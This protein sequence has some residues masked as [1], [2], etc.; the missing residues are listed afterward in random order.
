MTTQLRPLSLGEILDRTTQLYRANFLTFAGIA[1]VPTILILLATIPL[2]GTAGLMGVYG[3]AAAAANGPFLAGVMAGGTVFGIVLL[4]ATVFSQAALVRAV[5]G[6]HTGR[7]LAVRQ[8]LGSVKPRFWR[9]LGVLLLQ[10]ILIGVVPAV[11]A[12]VVIGIV[13]ALTHASGGD[14]GANVIA[15][16]VSFFIA[17][18]TFVIII[19]RGLSYSLAM[20]AC[21]AEEKPAW[22]S[23]QRSKKLSHG[24]RGRIFLM[25]LL[26]WVLAMVVSMGGYIAMLIV[27]AVAALVNKG[28][29]MG[30]SVIVAGEVVNMLVNLSI[31]TV[32][33]PVYVTALVL[34]YYDQRIRTEGY[35]I[36][37]MMEHAG[38]TGSQPEIAGTAPDAGTLNG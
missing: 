20:P 37:W 21:I 29:H 11:V 28:G 38:L 9:Y 30:T 6:A 33:T 17:A 3:R 15:G 7:P 27:M 36:E 14:A 22:E 31:Q 19:L 4:V 24:A 16:I 25:F 2:L 1:A 12:G 5:T 35:D 13:F 23:L 34:F 26:I 18:A 32:I 8:A 10:G